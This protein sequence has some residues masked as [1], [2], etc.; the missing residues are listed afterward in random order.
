MMG[1]FAR[2]QWYV[3]AAADEAGTTPL[4][5]TVC[6]VHLVLLRR[7]DGTPVALADQCPHRGYATLAR[8]RGRRRDPV[9]LSRSAL[10]LHRPLHVGAAAEPHP[11]TR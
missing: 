7:S 3:A 5:R 2:D 9:R 6:G 1:A 4:A 11:L 8:R 10:R